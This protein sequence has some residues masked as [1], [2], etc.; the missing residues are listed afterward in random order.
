LS[1]FVHS[2]KSLALFFLDFFEQ[3]K[4]GNKIQSIYQSFSGEN[5]LEFSNISK[6]LSIVH[7]SMRLILFAFF[8]DFKYSSR[9]AL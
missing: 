4:S 7:A 2:A 8:I 5:S 9:N 6:R 3:T 1:A